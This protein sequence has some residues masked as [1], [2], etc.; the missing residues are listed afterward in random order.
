MGRARVVVKRRPGSVDEFAKSEELGKVL[1]D[2]FGRK[3]LEAAQRDPNKYYVST[4]RMQQFVRTGRR[5][6]RTVQVGAAD[7]IGSRVERKR[8]TLARALGEA[9]LR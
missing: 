7:P 8:G 4:L 9:G 3:V 1:E 6:R 2:R 5:G